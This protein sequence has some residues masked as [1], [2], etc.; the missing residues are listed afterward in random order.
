[1]HLRIRHHAPLLETDFCIV[2]PSDQWAVTCVAEEFQLA[3]LLRIWPHIGKA[4]I[5]DGLLLEH[6]AIVHYVAPEVSNERLAI[7]DAPEMRKALDAV[8]LDLIELILQRIYDILTC[9]LA[10]PVLDL[11]GQAMD[12]RQITEVQADL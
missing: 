12:R 5:G 3:R 11:A 7:C 4:T 10:A 6:S 9:F 8:V 1:M 2:I